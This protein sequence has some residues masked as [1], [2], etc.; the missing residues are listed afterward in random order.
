MSSDALLSLV[1]RTHKARSLNDFG[2]YLHLR[3]QLV[4]EID[5]INDDFDKKYQTSDEIYC[6]C[7][8][9]QSGRRF[10]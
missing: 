6:R 2:S 8:G 5:K 9:K 10:Q 4:R 1:L 7:L 3:Q